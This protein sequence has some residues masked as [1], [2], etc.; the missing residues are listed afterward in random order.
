MKV[1]H[2]Y[3]IKRGNLELW[4]KG[5]TE[6]ALVAPKPQQLGASRNEINYSYGQIYNLTN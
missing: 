2:V 4:G 6:N 3:T 1:F 5:V